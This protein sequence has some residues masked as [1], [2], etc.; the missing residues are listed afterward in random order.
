MNVK[1][2]LERICIDGKPMNN[3]LQVTVDDE[4]TTIVYAHQKGGVDP[5][6]RV[7]TVESEAITIG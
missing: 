7:I 5:V 2:M 3:V 1:E 6:Q 4:K